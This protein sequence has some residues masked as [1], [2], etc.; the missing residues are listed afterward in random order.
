MELKR[1]YSETKQSIS[2]GSVI[3]LK[4]VF[5]RVPRDSHLHSSSFITTLECPQ[6]YGK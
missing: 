4:L 6:Y 1:V 2:L 3:L 5:Q